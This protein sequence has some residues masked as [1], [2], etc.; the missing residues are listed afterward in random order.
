VRPD[1]ARRSTEDGSVRV[2]YQIRFSP[3][4][5]RKPRVR[6]A[7]VEARPIVAASSQPAAPPSPEPA[8]I[9]QVPRITQL[10]VLGYHF[11]RLVREGVVQD[12]AEIARLTGLTRAR[13]TQIVNLTLLD[14]RIQERILFL[15]VA[16]AKCMQGFER[17]FRVVLLPSD[18]KEQKRRFLT[19]N[20]HSA[21]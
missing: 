10:L 19:L 14:P 8:P 6:E 4:Q 16:D 20:G 12:Y 2:E 21:A 9:G 15:T 3:G 1:A 13:V 7:P 18:W 11:E 5:G 17:D